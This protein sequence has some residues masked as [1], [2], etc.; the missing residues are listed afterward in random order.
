MLITAIPDTE[1]LKFWWWKFWG[2]RVSIKVESSI[3]VFL[4]K[5]FLFSCSDIFAAGSV[6]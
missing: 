5:H 3:V 4:E 6:I 2:F 1:I